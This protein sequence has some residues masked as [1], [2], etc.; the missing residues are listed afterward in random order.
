MPN[1]PLSYT[2]AT[3]IA[4]NALKL[5]PTILIELR[6]LKHFRPKLGGTHDV[7]ENLPICTQR[8]RAGPGARRA[9]LRGTGGSGFWL[10]DQIVGLLEL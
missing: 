10:K 6:H 5:A 7:I 1:L 9:P 8:Y 3:Y 4:T 2:I